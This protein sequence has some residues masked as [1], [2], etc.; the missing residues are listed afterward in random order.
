MKQMGFTDFDSTKG[1]GRAENQQGPAK[2][3]ISKHKKR[4]YRQYMNRR[5]TFFIILKF[6]AC[7]PANDGMFLLHP[8]TSTQLLVP[9]HRRFCRRVQSSIIQDAM[10]TTSTPYPSRRDPGEASATDQHRLQS[11]ST[12]FSYI[13]V[14]GP[15]PFE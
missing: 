9:S 5:G 6:A 13:F 10:M 11:H 8:E 15:L 4:E 3:A 7:A 2:G 1:K 14:H 12:R